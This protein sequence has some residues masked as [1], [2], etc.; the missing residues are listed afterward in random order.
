MV[1]EAAAISVIIRKD[2]SGASALPVFSSKQIRN[3][4]KVHCKHFHLEWIFIVWFL[5][6]MLMS[7][8]R[9]TEGARMDVSTYLAATS[10]LVQMATP[11]WKTG[12][13]ARTWTSAAS[14]RLILL[15]SVGMEAPAK[16]RT[17]PTSVSVLLAIECKTGTAS[18][19]TLRHVSSQP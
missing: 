19:S 17:D 5:K 6:K 11:W 9:I 8:L 16:I 18:V 10:A 13:V 1:T 12:E 7:A 4:V 3:H 15:P 14:S 2:P